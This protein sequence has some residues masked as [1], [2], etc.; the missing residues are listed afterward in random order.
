MTPHEQDV[1]TPWVAAMKGA[2]G[3]V[4]S[5]FQNLSQAEPL[6]VGDSRHAGW[7][8]SA[9]GGRD[10]PHPTSHPAQDSLINAH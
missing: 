9:P 8:R 10:P 3:P 5:S 1:T 4:P 6:Q 7:S 2:C